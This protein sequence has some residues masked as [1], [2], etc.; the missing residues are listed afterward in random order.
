MGSA[1]LAEARGMQEQLV[2]WRR[3]MHAHPELTFQEKNTSRWVAERLSEMGYEPEEKVGGVYGVTAMLEAGG[4]GPAVALRA[5]MDALPI[6]EQTGL[7]YA[8]KTPGV[9]HACGHDAHTSMLLGA[10]QILRRHREKLRHPVKFIFQPAEEAYPGGAAP[11]IAG[12]VLEG[13][14]SIFGIHIWSELPSGML[15]SRAGPFMASVNRLSIRVRGKGGHAAAP[16]LCVDPVV[17]AAQS[18]VALQT[19]VSRTLSMTESAVVSITKIEAGSADN[20]IPEEVRMLGT[21][22]TLDPKVRERVCERV[23]EVVQGAAGSL[24]ATAEV[25]AEEGYPVLVNDVE[26]TQ[27]A[28]AAAR[29]VGLAAENVREIEPI[30]GGEDFAYYC[31]RTAGAFVFLGAR[32]PEKGCVYSHHHPKFNIDED[33]L[34]VGAALHVQ[35]CMEE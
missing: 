14:K 8:S 19:V 28:F 13:V 34:A 3:H 31:Q 26:A 35:Y 10:A 5:D 1:I 4:G 6:E 17:A 24:G 23:R 30:G 2:A 33:M 7:E 20:V 18:I 11:M 15:G 29:R 32:N 16:H 27:R 9:M 22:R 12:G 21:I 25:T